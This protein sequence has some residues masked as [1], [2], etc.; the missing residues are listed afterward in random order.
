MVKIFDAD[1]VNGHFIVTDN[2]KRTL[3]DTG[4][5]VDIN[6]ANMRRFP[7]LDQHLE[8]AR[9]F[10][11]PSLDEFWGLEYFAQHKVLLD[12]KKAA[13]I[14]ADQSDDVTVV[15]PIAEYPLLPSNINPRLIIPMRIAGVERKMVFDSGAS[16]A[17]YITKSIAMTGTDAGSVIDEHPKVGHIEVKLFELPVEIGREKVGIRFG[18]QPDEIDRFVQADGAVGIIGI[19]LY[20]KYQVLID[21]PNKK[22]VL[23]KY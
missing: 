16:I 17:N 18:I 15:H 9:S 13:V 6:P 4:C 22:L 3:I 8:G 19:G 23:G 1:L 20:E 10:V 12:Y 7:G 21:V 11:D 2:G 14:V 5:P